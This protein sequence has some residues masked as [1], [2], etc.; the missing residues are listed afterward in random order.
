M[1]RLRSPI[2]T[3]GVPRGGPT[4]VEPLPLADRHVRCHDSGG[5]IS[6]QPWVSEAEAIPMAMTARIAI[7]TRSIRVSPLRA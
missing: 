2:D 1:R 4:P 7:D 6:F 5:H 3:P